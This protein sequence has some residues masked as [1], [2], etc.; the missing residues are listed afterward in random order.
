MNQ[1]IINKE[2]WLLKINTLRT[3]T[4]KILSLPLNWQASN[5]WGLK[6]LFIHLQVWDEEYLSILKSCLS[7]ESYLPKFCH[8]PDYKREDQMVFINLWNDQVINE[9][10]TI[11]LESLKEQFIRTREKV[12]NEFGKLWSD[13]NGLQ[14]PFA[15]QIDDLSKHDIEHISKVNNRE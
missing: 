5:G 8:F 14:H 6:E 7:G 13:T 3:S 9:R 1:K 15:T 12:F 10:K 4:N 2:E 11:S